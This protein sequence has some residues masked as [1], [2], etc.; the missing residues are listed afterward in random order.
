MVDNTSTAGQQQEQQDSPQKFNEPVVSKPTVKLVIDEFVTYEVD[1][2][3][4]IVTKCRKVFPV[5]DRQHRYYIYEKCFVAKDLAM[6]LK[7]NLIVETLQE[8]VNMCN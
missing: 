3:K 7:Q 5:R 6:W 8:A 2:L 4:S 1:E